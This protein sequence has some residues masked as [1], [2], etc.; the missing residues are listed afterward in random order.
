MADANGIARLVDQVSLILTG[1][2]E[3]GGVLSD[4]VNDGGYSERPWAVCL[5]FKL[6]AEYA[7]IQLDQVSA[8]LPACYENDHVQ[9]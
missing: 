8:A 7:Q 1:I 2:G 5:A 4:A 9:S 3:L 6:L